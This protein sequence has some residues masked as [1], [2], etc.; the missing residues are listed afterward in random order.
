MIVQ[1]RIGIP[2]ADH[3]PNDDKDT[4]YFIFAM[5]TYLMKPFPKIF[6]SNEKRIYNFRIS[7]G[8]R[9]SENAFWHHGTY[10][11]Y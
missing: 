10:M 2:E 11:A 7:R 8:R 6:M 9:I 1:D 5:R 4:P 3:L